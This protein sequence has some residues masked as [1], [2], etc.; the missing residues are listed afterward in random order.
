MEIEVKRREENH[1]DTKSTK[2]T[3]ARKC[4][5]SLWQPVKKKSKRWIID[6]AVQNEF[7]I[8]LFDFFF[9]SP[10]CR[11]AGYYFQAFVSFV[12]FVSLWFSSLLLTSISITIRKVPVMM[13]K[14]RFYTVIIESI[15]GNYNIHLNGQSARL[16]LPAAEFENRGSSIGQVETFLLC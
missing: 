9:Y 16:I 3:K 1:K 4:Y 12:L 10:G 7:L 6:S 15:K 8:H 14:T 2:G 5:L 11:Q 13:L